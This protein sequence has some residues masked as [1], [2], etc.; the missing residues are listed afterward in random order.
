M[1]EADEKIDDAKEDSEASGPVAG[2][3]L[4]AARRE[5]QIPIVEIAKELHLDEYKVRAL[6]RNEFDVIGAPVFAKGH[7][8]KYAQLVGVAQDDVMADY[9]LLDRSHGAPPEISLRSRPR[10]EL[11][12]GPWV[13]AIVAAL[14]IAAIYWWVAGRP[15]AEEVTEPAAS[16]TPVSAQPPAEAASS[17]EPAATT[18]ADIESVETTSA[19]ADAQNLQPERV[20]APVVIDESELRVSVTYSGDCWTEITDANGR[21]LFF[22]LGSAGQ[23]INLSG[24]APFNVLFGNAEYVSLRV[25][26][27]PYAIA[28]ADRRG[29]TARLTITAASAET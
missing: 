22:N 21:R 13:A 18:S 5:Q 20:E 17:D 12:P 19:E 11:S 26:D 14:V 7:L 16:P 2:E 24:E 27:Q 28:A 25:N 10:R 9:H 15:T 6:E 23:T 8:R 1:S 3:R 4:A 29:R